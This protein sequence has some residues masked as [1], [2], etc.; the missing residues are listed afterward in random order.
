LQTQRGQTAL[1]TAELVLF[2][3]NAVNFYG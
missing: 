2:S 1:V 3:T